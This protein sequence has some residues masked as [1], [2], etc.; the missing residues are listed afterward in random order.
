[1]VKCCEWC[2]DVLDYITSVLNCIDIQLTCT[3]VDVFLFVVA[4]QISVCRPLLDPGKNME[5]CKAF[6]KATIFEEP[7]WN[8]PCLILP[9]DVM[10][11]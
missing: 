1:M 10:F 8:R 4:K 11:S 3:S 9:R 5:V 6:L 2:K 7:F